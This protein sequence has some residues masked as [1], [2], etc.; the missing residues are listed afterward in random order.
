MEIPRRDL[1]KLF[2]GVIALSAGPAAAQ[3]A[4]LEMSASLS[5]HE[6]GLLAK[7]ELYNPGPRP[8][9]IRI[10]NSG[11]YFGD[12]ELT[13]HGQPLTCV[14]TQRLKYSRRL[15][16]PIWQPLPVRAK[17][18]LGEYQFTRQNQDP[19]TNSGTTDAA[20]TPNSAKYDL[21][22]KIPT[23]DQLIVLKKQGLKING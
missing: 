7:I 4:S 6:G 3:A 20:A 16:M 17:F 14:T 5:E 2:T 15:I 11:R 23:R 1:F 9:D 12:V 18:D 22:L 10:V 13:Q 19:N 21:Q 8:V